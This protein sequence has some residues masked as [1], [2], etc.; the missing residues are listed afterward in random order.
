[1]LGDKR[2]VYLLYIFEF[3]GKIKGVKGQFSIASKFAIFWLY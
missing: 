3:K 1:M 2:V